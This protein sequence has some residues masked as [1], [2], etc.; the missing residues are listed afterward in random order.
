FF[1]PLCDDGTYGVGANAFFFHSDFTGSDHTNPPFG[2]FMVVNGSADAG[3][4][5]WCQTINVEPDTDYELTFWARDVTNNSDPHPLAQLA[6]TIDG[7][8]IGNVLVAEGGWQSNTV[9]WNSG[10]LTTI[11]LCIV[12]YQDQTGGNDFGIDD[13]SMTGCHAYQLLHAADAGSDIQLCSGEVSSIGIGG[14]AGYSYNWD[15][16][17]G[18]SD[19]GVASPGIQLFNAGPDVLQQQYVLTA[20]SAGV[21]CVSTDTVWVTVLPMPTFSLGPDIEICPDTDTTLVVEGTWE[22]VGWNDGTSEFSLL[23]TGEG[24][25]WAEVYFNTCSSVDSL[26]I[27]WTDMPEI[28]L[29]ADTEACETDAPV[30]GVSQ[31]VLWSDGSTGMFLQPANSGT[32]WCTYTSGNCV[33]SDTVLITLWEMPEISLPDSLLLCA[34]ASVILDAGQ[35]VDWSNGESAAFINITSPGI[36]GATLQNGMCTVSDGT[37]VY[38]VALPV[39]DLGTEV[40]A[41]DDAEVELSAFASQ[42]TNYLWSDGSTG[43][44]VSPDDSGVWWVEVSNVC[45]TMSDTVEVYFEP[46]GF[47]LFIPNAFTPNSDGNNEGWMV[48]GYNIKRVEVYVYNRLGDLIFYSNAVNDPWSPGE[49]LPGDDVYNFRVEA[50]SIS[51]ERIERIGHIYLLR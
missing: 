50:E 51:G 15:N 12:N 5:V 10:S 34:G 24:W 6:F 14:Y 35:E 41:C 4:T 22:S 33:V 7:V 27:E 47:D 36:Y 31:P 1:C 43:S 30:L 13:I 16:A 8:Q 28:N 20:D 39:V 42:N 17:A 44:S 46:C 29:G 19:A 32:Y 26:W 40:F 48:T 18:L 25:Y 9:S 38:E 3:A 2:N 21:G 23:A 45:G 11:L 49:W 37:V